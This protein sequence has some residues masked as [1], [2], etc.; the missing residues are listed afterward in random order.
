MPPR[1]VVVLNELEFAKQNHP[2]SI[3]FSRPTA[4]VIVRGGGVGCGQAIIANMG[5]A[6]QVFCVQSFCLLNRIINALH[7]LFASIV[8]S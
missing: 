5:R 3:M 4:A 7:V 8:L 1:S 2:L 6:T